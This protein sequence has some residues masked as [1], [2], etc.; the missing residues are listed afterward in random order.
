MPGTEDR[1]KKEVGVRHGEKGEAGAGLVGRGALRQH[2]D[3]DETGR[4][5]WMC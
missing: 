1:G 4:S 2:P 3:A 5:A